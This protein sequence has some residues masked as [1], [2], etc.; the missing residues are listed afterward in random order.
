MVL[1]CDSNKNLRQLLPTC[2]KRNQWLFH[3]LKKNSEFKNHHTAVHH[4]PMI[5]QST[6]GSTHST[7]ALSTMVADTSFS[8]SDTS[9]LHF[10]HKSAAISSS[11][12]NNTGGSGPNNTVGSSSVGLSSASSRSSSTYCLQVS[13]YNLVPSSNCP[14]FSDENCDLCVNLFLY[15]VNRHI[16]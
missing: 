7:S 10:Y 4:Q 14:P 12:N 5:N 9:L 8:A 13:L 15:K 6:P 16:I 3:E 1:Q 11:L 2:R